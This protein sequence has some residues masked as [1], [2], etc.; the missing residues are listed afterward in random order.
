MA[1]SRSPANPALIQD[2]TKQLVLDVVQVGVSQSLSREGLHMMADHL[3]VDYY[4]EPMVQNIV[5][6][7]RTSLLK[8]QRVDESTRLYR[9]PATAWD[10]IKD[11]FA[12]EWFKEQW[13]VEYASQTITT[14]T[15]KNYLCPHL[16]IPQ[17]DRHVFWL[18]DPE[19]K[20]KSRYDYE[21][22]LEDN[23]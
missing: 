20:N 18:Y 21:R 2:A 13:P 9:Y 17:Q 6:T 4:L 1:I 15:E 11:K 8:K 7:F 16:S 19:N 5:Y 3:K 12:P 22:Y 23:P 10:Y 14:F